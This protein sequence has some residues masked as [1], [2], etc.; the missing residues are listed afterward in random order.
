MSIAHYHLYGENSDCA[1][2]DLLHIEP[3]R[4]R[5]RPL[6]WTIRPHSHPDHAQI[7]WIETGGG[8]I[9][10]ELRHWTFAAPAVVL[11]PS[12]VVHHIRFNAQTDG[13]AL[14]VDV[15]AIRQIAQQEPAFLSLTES[16]LVEEG[17]SDEAFRRL[18]YDLYAEFSQNLPAR[19]SQLLAHLTSIHVGLLRLRVARAKI[20]ALQLDR[21][22]TLVLHY[23]R[24]V[25]MEFRQE[26]SISAY[27]HR[28]HVTPARLN[29]AC[30]KRLGKTA[31]EVLNARLVTEAKRALIFTDQS[32]GQIGYTLGFEDPAYFNRFF[33]RHVGLAPGQFRHS[34][35]RPLG[36]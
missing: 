14:T 23:R 26:K 30:K 7:L 32:V 18:F 25:D 6:D 8:E 15:Q 5:S 28:L 10:M 16:P 35:K 11:I 27:A 29:A 19:G 31:S 34:A 22:S 12:G 9:G 13:F 21:D 2:P 3:I 17:L 33:S 36:E 20:E 24:L 4:E 1:P